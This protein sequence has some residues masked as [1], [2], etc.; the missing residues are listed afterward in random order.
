MTKYLFTTGNI[1]EEDKIHGEFEDEDE[2]NVDFK[3][4]GERYGVWIASEMEMKW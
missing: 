2:R 3:D 1:N 4:V